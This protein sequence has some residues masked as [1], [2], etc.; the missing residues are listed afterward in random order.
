MENVTGAG[1]V[2]AT[3]RVAKAAPDGY[4]LLMG[5][6]FAL[7]LSPSLYDK[8]PYDPVRNFAP[9]S[10]VFIAANLLVIHPVMRGMG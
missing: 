6:N 2:I 9:I 8:L 1:G 4:T 7:T 10:Q 3:N 5:G